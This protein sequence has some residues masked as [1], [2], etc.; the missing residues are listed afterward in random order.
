MKCKVF[1]GEY[2]EVVVEFNNWAK[3]KSLNKDIIIHSSMHYVYEREMHIKLSIVVLYPEGSIWD[4]ELEQPI[5]MTREE[6]YAKGILPIPE[7]KS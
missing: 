2:G 6:A 4:K 3:G 7:A 1:T 5:R